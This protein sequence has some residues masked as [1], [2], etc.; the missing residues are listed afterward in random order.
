MYFTLRT[1]V[2][3]D[4]LII[5]INPICTNRNDKH[6]KT[7]SGLSVAVITNFFVL[8]VCFLFPDMV[9]SCSTGRFGAGL[10]TRLGSNLE[11][12]LPLPSEHW[13]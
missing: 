2:Q 1:T 11:I 13:D 10:L 5:I 6:T 7:F 12:C 3:I 4:V 9:S 8:F